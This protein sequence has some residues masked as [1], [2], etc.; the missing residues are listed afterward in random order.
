[1][2]EMRRIMEDMSRGMQALQGQEFM[3]AYMEI[4]ECNHGDG[5]RGGVEERLVIAL[6]LNSGGIQIEVADFYGN[7]HVEDYLD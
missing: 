4:L 2:T 6:G 7:M 3:D 5:D 1:M